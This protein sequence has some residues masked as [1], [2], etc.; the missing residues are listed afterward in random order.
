MEPWTIRGRSALITGGN[1]GIG[2]ATATELARRGADVTIG[3]R[4]RGRGEAAV[5]AIEEETG[6][7]VGILDIDLASID[8]VRTA[9]ERFAADHPRLDVLLL[10]AGVFYGRHRTTVDGF[11]ATI[12]I[13]HLGH[14]LLAGL[15]FPRLLAAGAARVITVASSA[16]HRPRTFDV[17]ELPDWRG[18]YRGMDAYARSKLANVLFAT[19]LARR[20]A[21]TRVSSYSLHPGMVSTRIA[22]DGDTVL[23]GL[24]WK[25]GRFRFLGP[26]DGAA[27]SVML[28]TAPD[29]EDR[30]GRYF[31][32]G[33][34]ARPSRLAQDP[35]IARRLWRR[36]EEI[37]G[38][39]FRP[40]R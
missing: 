3:V 5:A 2:R 26:T 27:T 8:S 29:I 33:R 35:Q 23:V 30:S 17:D 28:A 36:S 24:L 11:E 12:G 13:N 40:D 14:F 25:L 9:A 4:D 1:A 34:E 7:S 18:R 20:T 39:R 38:L 19:E 16:H 10:N 22:Q 37:V 32:E 6:R 31:S 21:G 15:L